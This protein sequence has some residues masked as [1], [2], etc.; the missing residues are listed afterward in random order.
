MGGVGSGRRWSGGGRK[1]MEGRPSIDANLMNREKRLRPGTWGVWRAP[2]EGYDTGYSTSE[3]GLGL[4]FEV[5]ASGGGWKSIRRT[6]AVVRVPCRL[7]GERSYFVCSGLSQTFCGRRAVKLYADRRGFFCRQCLGLAYAS[8][9]ERGRL[10][11]GTPA[12]AKGPAADRRRPRCERHAAIHQAEKH[13]ISEIHPA[14]Q[15]RGNS[16]ERRHTGVHRQFWANARATWWLGL[17]GTSSAMEGRALGDADLW[18]NLCAAQP[19]KMKLIQKQHATKHNGTQERILT[20]AK[21]F[22]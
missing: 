7:G 14:L 10:G 18:T 20:P 1:T 13:A 22:L 9:N 11:A 21:A 19:L 3:A 5:S 6:V 2:G 16:E 12:G 17:K 8:Q 15:A 4:A